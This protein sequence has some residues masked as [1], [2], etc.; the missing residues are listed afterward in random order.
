[1]LIGFSFENY[2]SFQQEATFTML[3]STGSEYLETN[4]FQ[5]GKDRLLKSALIYGPN[6]SGKTNWVKAIRFMREIVLL[7]VLNVELLKQNDVFKFNDLSSSRETKFEISFVNAGTVYEYGFSILKGDITAE[8]LSRK[9]VRNSSVFTRSSAAWESISLKGEMKKAEK[10]KRFTRNNSLFLTT[11]AMFNI[12]EAK[13][14]MNWFNDLYI[15][16]PDYASPGL[17]IR[18]LE[19]DKANKAKLLKLLKIADLGIQDFSYEIKDK[20]EE[21]ETNKEEQ[22][23]EK[24]LTRTK[25]ISRKIDLKTKHHVYD[26]SKKKIAELELAFLKYQSE[27]TIKYF[28]I[29][30]PM[31]DGLENGKTLIIDEIDARL[32]T[33]VLSYILALFNSLDKNLQNG[34]LICNTHNTLLLDEEIRRDQVWF[35]QKDKYGSSE[36]YCLDDFSDVRKDDLKLKKYLLGVYGAIPTMATGDSYE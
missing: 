3:A 16:G 5:I 6:G 2:A 8:W 22:K 29:L 34:Q 15:L 23:S 32:H 30:G 21:D 14:I 11:A 13:E 18:Y 36:L 20:K 9:V 19:K 4:S 27:G 35:I 31:L 17:T 7:S 25:K 10:I 33:G 24:L 26:D 28:E 1:M 12:D